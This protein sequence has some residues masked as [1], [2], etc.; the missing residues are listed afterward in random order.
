MN[1]NT[2]TQ[3]PIILYV[4]TS[5]SMIGGSSRYFPP[6]WPPPD[7]AS[8]GKTPTPISSTGTAGLLLLHSFI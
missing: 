7:P 4:K 6:P 2:D 5:W 1:D 3:E 8:G